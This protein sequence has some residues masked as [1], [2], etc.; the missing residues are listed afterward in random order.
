MPGIS[1]G[2]FIAAAERNMRSSII[3]PGYFQKQTYLQISDVFTAT[4]GRKVWDALNNQTRFWNALRKVEWGTTVGWRN[5]TDRGVGRSRP[6][7]ETGAT[8]SNLPTVDVSAYERISSNPRIVASTFGVTVLG[9]LVS[10]LEG[11]MGDN[12][13]VEQEAAARDHIK[14]LNQ[15]ILLKGWSAATTAGASGTGVG[16][17]PEGFIRRGDGFR[18]TTLATS[19]FFRTGAGT[20][21]WV[22]RD[23]G[24]ATPTG[25]FT[26]DELLFITSRAGFT[27]IDDIV[28]EDGRTVAGLAATSLGPDVYNQ[29]TRTAAAWNAGAVILDNDGTGR[30]LSINLV[31]NALRTPRVNGASPDLFITGWDQYD[32]LTQILQ[33]QQRYSGFEEF[34]VKVGDEQTL[35]GT[36]AGFQIAS[37]RG[38]PILPDTDAPTSFRTNTAPVTIGSKFYCLD[39]QY[40]EIAIAAPTQYIDN[41]DFFQASGFFLRGLFYTAGELRCFRFNAQAKIEDL[42]I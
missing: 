1:L 42:N 29:T 35:P 33:A 13:A 17:D 3:P 11:G 28:E 12:L 2:E 10:G 37:Y 19:R 5:R 20:G 41:R 8:I 21:T 31:D 25:S 9:Q 24:D 39:S 34:V 15:E 14:E 22:W 23:A 16:F 6:V 40:L 32:R 7:V 27:S 4:F 18:G 26:D 38:V 30:N 36:H